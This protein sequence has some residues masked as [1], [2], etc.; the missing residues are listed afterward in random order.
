MAGT[1]PVRA[2]VDSLTAR[3]GAGLA[4]FLALRLVK[5]PRSPGWRARTA[6]GY[7]ERN[8]TPA[9]TEALLRFAAATSE[10]LLQASAVRAIRAARDSRLPE[11]LAAERDRLAAVGRPLP[12]SVAG[13]A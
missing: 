3:Y 9:V 13:L 7:L 11:K 6:L 12:P 10:P 1:P 8:P 5:L 2:V 4:G